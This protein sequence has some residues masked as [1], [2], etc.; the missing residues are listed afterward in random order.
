MD[1]VLVMLLWLVGVK[2]EHN[3]SV[4]YI[5]PDVGEMGIS[6]WRLQRLILM[7]QYNL[8]HQIQMEEHTHGTGIYNSCYFNIFYS[9]ML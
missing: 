5:P 7:E 1:I 2:L 3:S 8:L 4:E 9:G 6:V